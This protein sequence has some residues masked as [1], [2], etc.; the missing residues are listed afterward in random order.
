MRSKG[1]G[2]GDG[3]GPKQESGGWTVHTDQASGQ[4]YRFNSTTGE[5]EWCTPGADD[6]SG[7]GQQNLNVAVVANPMQA[8]SYDARSHSSNLYLQ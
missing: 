8:S 1:G 2:G 7:G 3:A 4:Q 5:T 6:S